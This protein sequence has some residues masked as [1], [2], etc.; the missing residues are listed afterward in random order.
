MK[1]TGLVKGW[2]W[3]LCGLL[4]I[5]C[6]KK[7]GNSEPALSD[8]SGKNRQEVLMNVA[9]NII[10]PSYANFKSKLDVMVS[11]SAAFTAA[12][13]LTALTEFRQA[14]QEAYIEWQ[15]VE[16]FDVGPASEHVLRSYMNIYPASVS[17]ITSN[18]N[19]NGK[20][21]L[22]V[23]ASYPAQ[24]FN[25][26]DY[27]LNGVAANDNDIVA[28]YTTDA[29]AALRIAYVKQLTAQMN[30]KFNQ[31]YSEWINGYRDKF[32]NSTGVSATSSF[33]LLVNGFVLNYE[34]YIRSGKFGI[35]SGAMTGG[36][37]SAERVECFYK[38]DLSL[39]LAK[40]A[41]QASIDFFNGKNVKTGME[42]PSFKTYLNALNA[43]DS[44]S[45][46]KLADAINTQF[47]SVNTSMN[48]LTLSLYDE[49]KTNNTA[50]INVYNEMQKSVRLLK[51][52]MTSAMSIII[53]Y[54]DND[55]D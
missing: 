30:T 52:D 55:G 18:I 13:T 15:K 10:I 9:D 35:P 6:N 27:L 46:I 24:G 33:S 36:T 50:I 14:W 37:P 28:F 42:G 40:T 44:Q 8:E 20:A 7:T 22:E 34:R 16:V 53:S 5:S 45:G 2:V 12:P 49:V 23:T 11:K 21:N 25:G 51:V 48:V 32:V 29:S 38:K 1:K 3:A 31:T 43:K 19:E 26:F 39:T 54:V 17:Q 4:I 41:H 47:T